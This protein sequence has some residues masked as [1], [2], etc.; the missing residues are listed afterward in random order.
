MT[1]TDYAVAPGEYLAEWLDQSGVT[2]ES[3]ALKFDVQLLLLEGFL[4][5]SVELGA[6][7]AAVLREATGV[8][9]RVW[10]RREQQYRADL[11]RLAIT[12]EGS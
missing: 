2:L 10:L 3:I 4:T 9:A 11:E 12:R 8:P 1:E 6:S 5:G 7:L